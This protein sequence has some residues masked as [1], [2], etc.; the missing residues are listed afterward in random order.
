MTDFASIMTGHEEHNLSDDHQ[1]QVGAPIGNDMS[2]L[3]KQYLADLIAKIDAK[4]IEILKPETF[5]V[6]AIYI[7]LP[8]LDRAAVD[9]SLF[10]IVHQVAQIEDFFRNKHTPNAAPQLQTMIDHLWQQKSRIEEKY[11]KI[12]KI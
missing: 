1:K 4:E 8:E 5:V 12:Y 10:N 11:G 7:R 2:A 3:H 9:V 6:N